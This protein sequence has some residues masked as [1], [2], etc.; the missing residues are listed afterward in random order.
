MQLR[1]AAFEYQIILQQQ[2]EE[3]LSLY[4]MLFL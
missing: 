3:K 1:K 2:N 4:N